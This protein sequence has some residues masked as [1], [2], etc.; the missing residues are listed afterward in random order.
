MSHNDPTLLTHQNGGPALSMVAAAAL[1]VDSGMWLLGEHFTT[2]V[3]SNLPQPMCKN[4]TVS[5]VTAG[6]SEADGG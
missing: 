6:R 4:K 5:L 3:G 1:E 2:D